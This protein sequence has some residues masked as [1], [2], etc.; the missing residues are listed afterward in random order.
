MDRATLEQQHPALFAQLQTE[1]AALGAT[2]ERTRIQA[3]ESA[4]IPGH[5][6]LIAAL[7][8]DGRTSGGD[9]ALAVNQA[10]RSIR[11]AQG[12]AA[13]SD[14]PLPVKST[15]APTVEA[16]LDAKAAAEKQRVA[17]LPVDDRCKAEWEASASLRAEFSSLGDYTALVKAEQNGKVRVLGKKT[18]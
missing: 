15:P 5:E 1:F 3:V 16:G 7:K 4:L 13:N 11:T 6:A 17:G 2:V 10:E 18:A 14:A 9:A 8:F 12:A